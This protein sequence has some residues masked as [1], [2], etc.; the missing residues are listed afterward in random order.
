MAAHDP[1]I[2]RIIASMGGYARSAKAAD[3]S[4]LTA[5]A[6]AASAERWVRQA[7]AL[8]PG[9]DEQAIAKVADAL[10]REHMQRMVLAR[11]RKARERR[12]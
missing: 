5:A 2:R 6:R 12:R 8:H 7:R 4:S 10:M 3:R 9:A 11:H 1:E